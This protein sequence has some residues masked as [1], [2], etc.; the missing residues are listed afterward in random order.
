VT[1]GLVVQVVIAG[2][3]AGAV[4]GLVAIGLTLVWR[5]T[6]VI[7]LAYGSLVGG[8][9]FLALLIAA[10]TSPVT[11]SSVGTARYL[12]A[13]AVT[14]IASGVAGALV[15]L[16]IL[17]PFLDRGSVLGWVGATV[18]IAFA[19][20]GALTP[21]FSREAYVLPD[22]L[23]FSR[24]RPINIPGG[25]TIQWRTLWVLAA[26]LVLAAAAGYV[27]TRTRFGVAVSAVSSEPLGAQIVG[28]PVARLTTIAFALAGALA[29]AGGIVGGPSGGTITTQTGL[30]LGLK[31]LAAALIAG[32]GTPGRVFRAALLLGVFEAAAVSLHV[33]GLPSLGLGPAWRNVAPIG[34]AL[35]VIAFRSAGLMREPSE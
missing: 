35:I 20:Q 17:R 11:S 4:Y 7:H 6:S 22:P 3:A 21:A 31:A 33:P 25:A 8:S 23:P 19:V 10:G 15:Y 5:L 27:L 13:V 18:G 1:F 32:F 28:L 2:L 9:V 29:A 30:L 34:L 12:L 26:G 14:L 24:W 16:G